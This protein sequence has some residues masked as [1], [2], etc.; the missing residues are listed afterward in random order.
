MS[1]LI[2]FWFG[3]A[4]VIAAVAF[5]TWNLGHDSGYNAGYQAALQGARDE[6]DARTVTRRFRLP[7]RTEKIVVIEDEPRLSDLRIFRK[8]GA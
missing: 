6:A 3:I 7:G 4:I 1:E 5:L 2:L 8:G